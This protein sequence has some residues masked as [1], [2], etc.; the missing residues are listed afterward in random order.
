MIADRSEIARRVMAGEPLDHI[1]V[2]DFHTHVDQ[3]SDY[4]FIPKSTTPEVVRYFDR[5][6]VDHAVVFTFA[7]HTDCAPGNRRLLEDTRELRDRFSPLVALHA[8]SPSEWIP[9]LEQ[10]HA[11]GARGIKL[12]SAYQNVPEARIDWSPVLDYA[13]DKNWVVLNHAWAS[14]E[15]LEEYATNFP[16]VIF[17]SGHARTCHA[18][19]LERCDNVFQC[20]CGHFAMV[21]EWRTEDMVNHLPV[22]KILYG[23]DA[24]DL[25]VG[26]AIGPIALADIPEADKERVLG[27]NAVDLIQ[28]LGWD[29]PTESWGG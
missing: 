25:D 2:V 28:R 20:T 26:T 27:R 29:L 23:S 3:S 8:G 1:P 22:E 24:L 7:L 11:A 6:G 4:Y 12:I 9:A 19:P 18:G 14:P 17:I 13:R 10:G 15:R 16:T 21:P 5:F